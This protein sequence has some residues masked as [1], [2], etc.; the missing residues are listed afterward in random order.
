MLKEEVVNVLES[1]GI[2]ADIDKV[3]IPPKEEFGDYAYPCFDLAKEQKKNPIELAKEIVKKIQISKFPLIVKVEARNGYVNFFFYWETIAEKVLKN[4]LTKKMDFA[5]G[6]RVMIEFSQPNP[7]HP[8]HIGHARGTFLG[9]SLANI[10]DFLGYKTI[11]ANYMNDTGLQVAKL[12]TAYMLWAKNKRPKGKPDHWLWQLY[13]K[14]H[15]EAK[16]NPALEEMARETLRQFEIRKNKDIQKIWKKI[17]KWCVRGFEETYKKIGIK[18]NVYFY[19]NDFREVGKDLVYDALRKNIAF[20]TQE[21]T[22]VA[23]LEKHGLPNTVLLRSDGTG[24]YITSDLGLTLHKFE[25]YKLDKSIWVVSSQQN[26]HFKQLFKILEL[27]GYP[28][29]S[30]CHHFS[31]EHVVLEEGKMSSRE[32]KAIMLD[33]V[34]EKLIKLAYDE[35]DKRNPKLPRYKK[36]KIAKE[37][38]IGALKYAILRIEPENGIT[39]DWK[40]MLSFEGNTGPYIQYAYTRCMGILKKAKAFTHHFRA[41]KLNDIEKKLVK[42]LLRFN[43]IIKNAA[44]EMKPHYI[45][46]YAYDLVSTFN[47]FYEKVPVLTAEDTTTRNFRLTLV[48]AT[49]QV[50]MNCLKLMGIKAL[51]KM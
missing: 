24:L 44:E 29:V 50:L 9:D 36:L 38:G 28:W 6:K 23:D 8:M 41:L 12:V 49:R 51:E 15:E 1:L 32:G 2:K 47:L 48:D 45:C 34:V 4:I 18:F 27:L 16:N 33:D 31:F 43:S 10:Y 40:Q 3:E 17:V 35:V 13:I 26:L 37:I 22:I 19:E 14:F 46:N 30:K 21:N 5:K 20:K 7:V 39:F 25:K 11:R 42:E